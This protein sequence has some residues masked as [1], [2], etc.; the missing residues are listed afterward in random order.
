MKSI[1][2]LERGEVARVS[3]CVL[4]AL[5]VNTRCLTIPSDRSTSVLLLPQAIQVVLY[6]AGEY[7]IAI[8]A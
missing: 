6:M 4:Q 3:I 5:S 8:C 1:P 2:L 7:D